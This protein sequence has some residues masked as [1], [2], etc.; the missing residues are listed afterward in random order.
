MV[1][2]SVVVEVG[3][4]SSAEV[5]CAE[6][7]FEAASSSESS[8]LKPVR[9][10]SE[11]I[12]RGGG[13]DVESGAEVDLCFF[14]GCGSSI[15]LDRCLERTGK[16]IVVLVVTRGRSGTGV[17]HFG[18]SRAGGEGCPPL[19]AGLRGV[20]STVRCP[21]SSRG[22]LSIVRG[23]R[24]SRPCVPEYLHEIPP[25]CVDEAGKGTNV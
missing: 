23:R 13:C 5:S 25:T 3:P 7:A 4:V 17:P 10:I 2:G 8:E 1:D 9:G 20:T 21:S 24:Y 15:G 16:G 19:G 18:V 11:M 14:F 6:G 12:G 22:W